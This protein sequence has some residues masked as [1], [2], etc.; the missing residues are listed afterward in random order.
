M[1]KDQKIPHRNG[2]S[3][4]G[5]ID[6][7]AIGQRIVQLRKEKQLRRI[8]VATELMYSTANYSKIE[9]GEICPDCR[10]LTTLCHIFQCQP[11]QIVYGSLPKSSITG[12][13]FDSYTEQEK[14]RI[15][16]MLYLACHCDSGNYPDA[17]H[18][19]FGSCA[20]DAI[21]N[22]ED[23]HLTV[24]LEYERKIHNLT[25][26][27]MADY[28]HISKNKYYSILHTGEL[29]D[30]RTLM[31]VNQILGYP[32]SFLLWNQVD[33]DYFF[34]VL[35]TG[36][37]GYDL[38]SDSSEILPEH[39]IPAAGQEISARLKKYSRIIMDIQKQMPHGDN[40]I[41]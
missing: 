41:L 13:Y 32:M 12:Q 34:S 31:L 33:P 18:H 10:G 23:N 26:R 11:E 16:R 36:I 35:Q 21:Y 30:L 19:L 38:P 4:D 1:Y 17:F 3:M 39:N 27:K 14:R 28:L 2:E 25:K 8:D 29:S 5:Q 37:E 7:R 22:K 9:K 24:L 15:L 20:L 40:K 6:G